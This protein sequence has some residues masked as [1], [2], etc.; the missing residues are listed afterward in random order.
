MLL[1]EAVRVD[2][3]SKSVEG[4]GLIA[5]GKVA[6]DAVSV[7]SAVSNAVVVPALVLQLVG[8]ISLTESVEQKPQQATLRLHRLVWTANQDPQGG[9]CLYYP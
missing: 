5:Q 4:G 1:G 3:T 6:A 2:D 8:W 9:T 7:L